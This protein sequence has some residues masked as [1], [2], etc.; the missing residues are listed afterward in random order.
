MPNYKNARHGEDIH[1]ELTA[2]FR[3]LKDPRIDPMLSIVRTELSRD[4][5]SCKVYVSSLE[6][7]QRAEESVKGLKSAAGF[8]RREVGLRLAMRHTP[9]FH[10]IADN[11]IEYGVHISRLLREIVPEDGATEEKQP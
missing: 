3:S 7:L 11:S 6:G 1:R 10:F 8:I 2:I 9:E 5:S 4:G